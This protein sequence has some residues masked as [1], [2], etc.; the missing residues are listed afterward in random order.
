MY[1]ID[2][3]TWTA[4]STTYTNHFPQALTAQ[5]NLQ[6]VLDRYKYFRA[7]VKLTLKLQTTLYHQGSLMVYWIPG[8]ESTTPPNLY[9]SSGCNATVLSAQTQDS[10]DITIPYLSPANWMRTDGG[11]QNSE[12]ARFWITPLNTLTVSS[13]AQPTTVY[14]DIYAAF[15][16][17]KVSGYVSKTS[18]FLKKK[19]MDAHSKSSTNKEAH[20]KM[21]EGIDSK[22]VV[23][24]ASKLL[25]RAPIVGPAYGAVADFVNSIAGDLSKPVSQEAPQPTISTYTPNTSLASGVSVVDQ[26]SLY[27]N[28]MVTQSKKYCG[29]ATSH[30][31]MSEMAQQPMLY[32]RFTMTDLDN[33]FV[34]RAAPL[35]TKSFAQG[36]IDWL[37]HVTYAHRLW[38]GSIKYLFHVCVPAFYSFRVRIY[39]LDQEEVA[40]E[41]VGEI[42]SKIVDI[43]GDTWI[44]YSVPYHRLT[45]WVDPRKDVASGTFNGMPIVHFELL[46]PILGSSAPS[47]PLVYVN[48]WRAGGEDTAFAGLV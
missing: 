24:V 30:M 7:D 13:A 27:P 26:L 36:T 21:H 9:T 48:V 41:N 5:P 6:L 10:V 18:S 4:V 11:G 8:W 1:L 2:R 14:L 15:I 34:I 16:N 3:Y 32:D 31:T 23:S 40:V 25:R 22:S 28:A 38:R 45:D 12:I 20:T 19:P 43:K 35:A 47:T 39:H 33:T 46:T 29:M 42:P 17:S 44:E 37:Y